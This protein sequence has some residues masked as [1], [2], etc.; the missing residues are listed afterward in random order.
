MLES[1]LTIVYSLI[2]AVAFVIVC[3]YFWK[4]FYSAPT[5]QDET[6]YVPT[7]DGWRLA[8]HR[9]RPQG[10]ARGAPVILC[11]G[12]SSNRYAFDLPGAP[13]LARF[14]RDHGRDVWVAEL[15]GSGLSDRP[16][17]FRADVP[18]SWAFEDHLRCDLPAII[19]R[20]LALTGFTQVHW[21]GHSM[22]GMLGLAHLAQH[23]NPGVASAIAIGSPADF[24]KIDNRAFGALLNV[25]GLLQYLPVF[26]LPL[27]ARLVLPVAHKMSPYLGGPYYSSNIEPIVARKVMALASELV[28]SNSMWLNFGSFLANGRFAPENGK[29]YLEELTGSKIPI[30]FVAGTADMMAPEES[31][32]AA[33]QTGEQSGERNCRIFGKKTGCVEDYGHTDLLVGIRSDHE[34]FPHILKWLEDHDVAEDHPCGMRSAPEPS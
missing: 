16:G 19:S 8:L 12:L 34:V 24:T 17:M 11:H 7:D 15:R 23:E 21:V 1:F 2:L 22:G 5:G 13:S 28:A 33:C 32:I 26:P 31:V 30:F 10:D 14:F 29:P 9:Y 20:V 6:F 25:R 27:L 4:A 18:Y 3:G